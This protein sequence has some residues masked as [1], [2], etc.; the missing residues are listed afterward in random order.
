MREAYKENTN[1]LLNFL[2]NTSIG[3]F[4][5]K[6]LVCNSFFSN[7]VAKFMDCSASKIIIKPF[8]KKNK[9]NLEDYEKE[10][11][12]S[13]NDFFVRKIKSNKRLIIKDEK[14]F[15]SPC[16]G[17]LTCY[18][19][20][21]K[22][23]FDVKNSKYSVSSITNDK[24]NSNKYKDGYVL[25]FRLSPDDYHRYCFVDDGK[26][27]N[28]YKISGL[29]HTVNPIVYDKH[30]VFKENTR[31]CTVLKTNNFGIITYVEVGALLVGKIKNIKNSGVVCKGE[32]KGFFMYG[33]STIVLLIEN[34]KIKIDDD[35]LCNSKN[36]C[37]TI[38]KYGEKIG[39][40]L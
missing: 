34:G 21:E 11:F 1:K 3:R 4:I 16:D 40:K 9:I 23:L 2:Y 10:K 27:I 20:D 18:K 15:I 32:E 36:K 14:S 5:L 6:P 30:M 12:K 22:L 13:F 24:K 39:Y 31:E 37:E 8:V 19:I 29:F 7:L 35:I 26:I 38:V 28:N 17:K 33:G 25:V